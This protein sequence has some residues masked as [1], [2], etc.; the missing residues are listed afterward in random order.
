M[1]KPSSLT[2]ALTIPHHSKN[3][4]PIKTSLFGASLLNSPALNKGAAF[5]RAERTTFGLEGLLP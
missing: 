2:R 5:S 4:E 1:L 3:L